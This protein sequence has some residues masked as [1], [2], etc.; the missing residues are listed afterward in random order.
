M[1]L[2]LTQPINPSHFP[3]S[4]ASSPCQLSHHT[5]N[6]CQHNETETKP[7]YSQPSLFSLSQ[8]SLNNTTTS[9]SPV[10]C[11][12]THATVTITMKLK[13]NL[14]TLFTALLVL[15]V[16]IQTSIKQL[17]LCQ[18]WHYATNYHYHNHPSS[19]H[20]HTLFLSPSHSHCQVIL[21]NQS[22]LSQSLSSSHS[23][24]QVLPILTVNSHTTQPTITIIITNFFTRTLP[25]VLPIL[26]TVKLHNQL[27]L[28]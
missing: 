27:S 3:P 13:Q 6:W 14:L 8:S 11:H 2:L 9:I 28:P 12:T 24:P 10:N 21:P 1:Q 7:A 22:S 18:Q 17:L 15:S 23:L 16:N 20:T 26:S 4:P 19:S 25:Q 5:C